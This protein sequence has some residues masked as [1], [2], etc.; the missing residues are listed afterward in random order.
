MQRSPESHSPEPTFQRDLFKGTAAD[1]ARYR[2]PYPAELG[3]WL[4]AELT[5]DGSGRLLDLASG[6]GHVARVLRPYFAR[7]VAVDSESDMVDYGRARSQ[8]E[9]DGIEWRLDRAEDVEFP[10]D[11]F[12]V[13]AAGNAFQRFDRPVVAARASRWLDR[14]GAVALLWGGTPWRSDAVWQRT[15]SSLIEEWTDRTGAAARVPEGWE[16]EDY[17]HE[18]VLRD[19]GFGR[20]DEYQL[21][22]GHTWMLDDIVGFLRSTSFASRSAMGDH[23]DAFEDDVRRSLLE[24]DEGGVYEQEIDFGAQ[25]ARR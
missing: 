11:S 12:D 25:I 9:G 22:V 16:R 8:R 1:Y 14:D 6:T 21:K 18:I 4:G 13:V 7:V 23:A 17:P 10:D 15:L 20:F 3:E 2:P 24:I 5:L 19:A